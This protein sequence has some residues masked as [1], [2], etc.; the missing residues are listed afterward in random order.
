[1]NESMAKVFEI[2]FYDDAGNVRVTHATAYWM[3]D[4]MD[5]VFETNGYLDIV[6]CKV[7]GK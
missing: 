5:K 6:S 4:A 7:V 1:M 3:K 2:K